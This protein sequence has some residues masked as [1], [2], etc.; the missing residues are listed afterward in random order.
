MHRGQHIVPTWSVL[1]HTGAA[2]FSAAVVQGHG[3]QMMLG[4]SRS[5]VSCG[6]TAS[7]TRLTQLRSVEQQTAA[8]FCAA[9]SGC[10]VRLPALLWEVGHVLL[11]VCELVPPGA[12]AEMLCYCCVC[13]LQL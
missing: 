7:E 8:R 13:L 11:V 10:S 2:P 9:V 12:Q 1:V 6:L 4:A 5:A 3:Q